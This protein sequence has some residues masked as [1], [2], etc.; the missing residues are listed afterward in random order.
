MLYT[1]YGTALCPV[2]EMMMLHILFYSCMSRTMNGSEAHP[3]WYC[4]IPRTEN[5][6]V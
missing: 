2:L 3:I 1:F 5:G 4:S 6:D